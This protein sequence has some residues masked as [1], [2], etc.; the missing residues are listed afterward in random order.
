MD[1]IL[2]AVW[3]TSGWALA[4]G[5]LR[6]QQTSHQITLSFFAVPAWAAASVP[7]T[8]VSILMRVG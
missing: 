3:I 5:L 8:V 4:H 1:S 7:L 2:W 6:V